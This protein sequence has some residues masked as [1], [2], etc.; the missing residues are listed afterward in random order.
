MTLFGES[1]PVIDVPEDPAEAATLSV[2]ERL[3]LVSKVPA[4]FFTD[5]LRE[6]VLP[7]AVTDYIG[8]TDGVE[9]I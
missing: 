6:K 2:I 7:D 1:S 8:I 5:T 9:S 3:L 4:L